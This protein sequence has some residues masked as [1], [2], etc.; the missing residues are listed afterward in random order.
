MRYYRIHGLRSQG[1]TWCGRARMRVMVTYS[2]EFCLV[3]CK[4]CLRLAVR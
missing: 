1:F 3:T 2:D 4:T